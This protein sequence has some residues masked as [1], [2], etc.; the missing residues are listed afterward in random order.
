MDLPGPLVRVK[1]AEPLEDFRVRLTFED[2]TEKEVDLEPYL[3]GPVFE[4]IRQDRDRFRAV[5][6]DGG[7]TA[8]DNGADLDPD[9]LYY[10]LT[11]AWMEEEG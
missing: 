5:N 9:V 3:C 10:G 2:G 4:P 6:V 11:P 1:A 7:T 8:W